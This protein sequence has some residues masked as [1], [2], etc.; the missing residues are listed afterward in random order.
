MP[1]APL[2]G[3][4]I[5]LPD[6][7]PVDAPHMRD[8][9]AGYY[10]CLERLDE[11]VGRLLETVGLVCQSVNP[12][13]RVSGIVLC[14]HEKQTTLAREIVADLD[15]FFESQRDEAVPAP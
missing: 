2:Q 7:C 12:A 6:F 13:L 14:M 15:G 10:N 8:R 11:G 9:L 4:D 1:A 3:A 5:Q